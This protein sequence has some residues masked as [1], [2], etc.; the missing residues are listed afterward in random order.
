MAP[1]RGRS[2]PE[3][4]R[5]APGPK[6][7]KSTVPADTGESAGASA[8]SIRGSTA[9]AWS[10]PGSEPGTPG[11]GPMELPGWSSGRPRGRGLFPARSPE[12]A[13]R[14]PRR[15][16]E[17][18]GR[19][20]GRSP[21]LPSRCGYP[22]GGRGAPGG[23]FHPGRTRTSMAGYACSRTPGVATPGA[24]PLGGYARSPASDRGLRLGRHSL[25]NLMAK[26][27]HVGGSS[28]H[29][30][31]G[32]PPPRRGRIGNPVGLKSAVF[33]HRARDGVPDPGV[34]ALTVE[35]GRPPRMWLKLADLA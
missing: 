11:S 21:V 26:A 3:R 7:G 13:G 19:S 28:H 23:D 30:G 32:Q 35:G 22:A 29:P 27:G 10:C 4:G 12:L 8:A 34:P 17:L 24:P 25:G 15:G 2:A 9:A 6:A 20:P 5:T 16:P 33:S 1:E 14:R 31:L 18:V